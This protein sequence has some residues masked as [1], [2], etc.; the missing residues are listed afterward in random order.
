MNRQF[1]LG[2][3]VG[4]RPR[5]AIFRNPGGGGGGLGGVAYKDWAR[6]P[7]R[8]IHTSAGGRPS[9]LSE[10]SGWYFQGL[11]GCHPMKSKEMGV[12]V[13]PLCRALHCPRTGLRCSRL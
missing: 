1:S 2:T 3:L 8:G 9:T 12:I 11:S 7:P 10:Y 13:S 6:P 4:G 5:T